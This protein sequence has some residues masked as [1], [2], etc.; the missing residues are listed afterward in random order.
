MFTHFVS[1]GSR[2]GICFIVLV[3]RCVVFLFSTIFGII[4]FFPGGKRSNSQW[5]FRAFVAEMT[6]LTTFKTTTRII[7]ICRRLH[8]LL[9]CELVWTAVVLGDGGL[10][11]PTKHLKKRKKTVNL[12]D[13][14]Q[15]IINPINGP[16]SDWFHRYTW[17][18]MFLLQRRWKPRLYFFSSVGP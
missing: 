8:A 18:S 6:L 13:G 4:E 5:I 11:L 17:R 7:R 2:E 9:P 12:D 15:K 1:Y 16:V 10:Q 14:A 3:P